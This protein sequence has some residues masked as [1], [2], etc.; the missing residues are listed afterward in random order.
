MYNLRY[1]I[2]SLVAVFLALALGLVLGGLVVQRGAFDKQQQAIVAGLQR[3]F[4]KLTEQN[5]SLKSDLDLVGGYSRQMTS[6]WVSDRLAGKTVLLM[7]DEGHADARDAARRAIED[8]GG[9]VVVVT[10][11]GRG[12]SLDQQKAGDAARSVV[13]TA[14]QDLPASVAASLTAEWLAPAPARPLTDALVS[15]GVLGV[16]GLAANLQV[17]AVVDLAVF[18]GHA[19]PVALA[20][21]GNA[22][23]RM[24]TV[25]AQSRGDSA[26]L[27]VTGAEKRISALDTLDTE[28][29]RFSLVALISGGQQGFWGF[30]KGANGAYPPMP[31][32]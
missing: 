17:T 13:G 18:D 25:C 8:A 12:L 20:V 4:K 10:F 7:A 19:D 23:K 30:G 27:A 3:D 24:P 11:R 29:G 1:H 9:S 15:A 6:A 28:Y 32:Q 5:K 26:D 31:A 22:A 2:A 21:A 16:E 14:T